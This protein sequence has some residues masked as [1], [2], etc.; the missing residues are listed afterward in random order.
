MHHPEVFTDERSLTHDSLTRIVG[1]TLVSQVLE[2]YYCSIFRSVFHRKISLVKSNVVH[3]SCV[4]K[5]KKKI[6]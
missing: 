2:L 4:T 1:G 5:D 3:A 6:R